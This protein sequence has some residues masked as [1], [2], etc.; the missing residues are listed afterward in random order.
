MASVNKVILLGNLGRDPDVRY[1]PSGEQVANVAIA[2]SRKYKNKA[3]ALIDETEWHRV[4]FFG[5]LAEIAAQYLHKGAPVYVE[6]RIHTNKYTDKDG[7]ERYAT[8]VVASEMQLLG[9]RSA[10]AAAAA[11][12]ADAPGPAPAPAPL[13]AAGGGVADLS[14]DIPF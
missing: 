12:V 9:T 8:T 3:G 10:D 4:A 11:P 2:T 1:L 5:R 6:G 13:P 14:D 7:A